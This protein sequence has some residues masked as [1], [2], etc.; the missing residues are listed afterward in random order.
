MEKNSF[1]NYDF[2]LIRGIVKSAIFTY[3][4]KQAVGL[5]GTRLNNTNKREKKYYL[6][7]LFRL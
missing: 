7:C 6:F 5:P 3:Y 2:F 1:K 4:I